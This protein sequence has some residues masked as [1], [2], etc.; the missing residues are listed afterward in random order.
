MHSPDQP[1]CSC[2]RTDMLQQFAHLKAADL[3]LYRR[4][5]TKISNTPERVLSDHGIL[6]I[7]LHNTGRVDVGCDL[8]WFICS[9]Q[10]NVDMFL[11]GIAG[12]EAQH[13]QC[14]RRVVVQ[15][16]AQMTG[17]PALHVSRHRQGHWSVRSVIH[18]SEAMLKFPDAEYLVGGPHLR[19]GLFGSRDTR[20]EWASTEHRHWVMWPK[21]H[22]EATAEAL[23]RRGSQLG[24]WLR[25]RPAAQATARFQD[26]GLRE[27]L[28]ELLLRGPPIRTETAGMKHHPHFPALLPDRCW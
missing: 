1:T 8:P 26:A 20:F 24:R 9:S 23:V 10:P 13:H 11:P 5:G 15:A 6:V 21:P 2:T 16:A 4:V 12:V 17:W 19:R 25:R 27:G 28:L 7:N 22:R 14:W 3:L 18:C